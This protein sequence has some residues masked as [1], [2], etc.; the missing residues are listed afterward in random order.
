MFRV[1][2]SA[3][4]AAIALEILLSE[5]RE[6]VWVRHFKPR[7]TKGSERNTFSTVF[8]SR[9]EL[10]Y[11]T[12]HRNRRS[13]RIRSRS[14]V[15][16][17]R[18]QNLVDYRKTSQQELDVFNKLTVSQNPATAI[19]EQER[20]KSASISDYQNL[21]LLLLHDGSGLLREYSPPESPPPSSIHQLVQTFLSNQHS[22]TLRDTESKVKRG[23]NLILNVDYDLP[24][25]FVDQAGASSYEPASLWGQLLHPDYRDRVC[26]ILSSR[27]LRHEDA[28]I[29]RHSSWERSVEDAIYEL[30][31]YDI[32]QP[33]LDVGHLII[34]FGV[35]AALYI[36]SRHSRSR[37]TDREAVFVFAPLARD[38]V[39]RD[40]SED[41][42]IAGYKVLIAA[43]IARSLLDADN[44][45][46][47]DSPLMVDAIRTGLLACMR[48]FDAGYQLEKGGVDV[49]ARS[50]SNV[51]H[52]INQGYQSLSRLDADSKHRLR[53]GEIIGS[54]D[55]PAGVWGQYRQ[56]R[57]TPA[58]PGGQEDPPWQILR[59][60]LGVPRGPHSPE[61]DGFIHGT[62][63]IN[64]ASAIAQYGHLMV[65]N[66]DLHK[67]NRD[68]RSPE[69]EER[70]AIRKII[71]MPEFRFA[72]EDR[73]DC[74][75]LDHGQSPIMPV[76]GAAFQGVSMRPVEIFDILVPMLRLGRL[77]LI[78][79]SEI[80]ALRSARNIMKDYALQDPGSPQSRQPI[81]IAI[82]GA[83]G[84]G[85]S[86][87]VK[88]LIASINDSLG[89]GRRKIELIDF[90]VSQFNSMD[91]LRRA[92]LRIANINSES[93]QTVLPC[94]FFDEF[95]SAFDGERL[96]WLKCFL[97]IMQ[98]G[99]FQGP[100]LSLRLGPSVL[101]FA[102]GTSDRFE[103]FESRFKVEFS[104]EEVKGLKGPDFVSRLLAH[105]NILP[106]D[107]EPHEFKF[108]IRRAIILR[109]ILHRKGVMSPCSSGECSAAAGLSRIDM[110]IVHAL[111][112]IDRYRHGVRSMEAIVRMASP[113][114]GRI[115]RA[116][117][118]SA[119][120]LSMHVDAPSFFMYMNR[121]RYRR[122]HDAL[123][124]GSSSGFGSQESFAAAEPQ[125]MAGEE[126]AS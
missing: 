106:I 126:T 104:P 92:C 33:L 111:L 52:T 39:H 118:P 55:V 125:E 38:G 6:N 98:D 3:N 14:R 40:R 117:L 81:S 100:D 51:K 10:S 20:L 25:L 18:D 120:Q 24:E 48:A 69:A 63:R 105:V 31:Q 8:P 93:A 7:P 57:S 50:M 2:A 29:A 109:E 103:T 114:D 80:E 89:P 16:D 101:V 113:I 65:V 54:A 49:L 72:Q 116:S 95:D 23:P 1:P 66:R 119:G 70:R 76:A 97:G 107:R 5:D 41:G 27:M 43:S 82:F 87:V 124:G 32:L 123:L 22:S 102:G 61:R 64:V 46:E 85:K 21:D 36:R 35:S 110:D 28:Q 96:G 13:L 47:S 86:F 26:V 37:S 42:D 59:S 79:R 58:A 77:T 121:S 90:N 44:A 11:Y 94:A 9:C 71:Q 99:V 108:V 56:I 75:T 68:D 53:N 91:D 4:F 62:V 12:N 115:E 74:L 60:S 19:D 73:S 17:Y 78:E 67:P 84:T 15:V 112:A 34:R 45:Q 88:Q 122:R 83:P 30:Q